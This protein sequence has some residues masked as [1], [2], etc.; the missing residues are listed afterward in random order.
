MLA[1]FRAW[2]HGH[3]APIE[4]VLSRA[5]PALHQRTPLPFPLGRAKGER[6]GRTVLSHLCSIS[7]LCFA[8]RLL[9]HSLGGKGSQPNN[10]SLQVLLP[11]I[12]GDGSGSVLAAARSL[13]LFQRKAL[14]PLHKFLCSSSTDSNPYIHGLHHM[15]VPVQYT[16]AST[17]QL[18]QPWQKGS[19]SNSVL[20]VG[21][22]FDCLC[23]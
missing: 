1:P 9:L 8:T 4:L 23:T 19:A 13:L 12:N 16:C 22:E 17:R 10:L 18:M 7:F 15:P 3:G 2:A 20:L 14:L 5:C 6:D 11:L 21:E